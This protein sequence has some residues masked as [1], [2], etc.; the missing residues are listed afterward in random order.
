MSKRQ[1]QK[2]AALTV[3]AEAAGRAAGTVARGVD[4]LEARHPHPLAEVQEL[5]FA[6]LA[7][8]GAIAADGPLDSAATSPVSE[9]TRPRTQSSAAD[10]ERTPR[11]RTKAPSPA[12]TSAGR[13]RQA[14]EVRLAAE[15]VKRRQAHASSQT[16]RRQAR[17][18]NKS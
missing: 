1:A 12:G 17:R 3:V 9:R 10:R 14:G 7:K 13:T 11:A 2:P 6:A 18:D 5:L 15:N 8:L 16:K 4:L